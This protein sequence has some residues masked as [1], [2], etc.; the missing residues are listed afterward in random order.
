MS[1]SLDCD[2]AQYPY[3]PV[4]RCSGTTSTTTLSALWF[5]GELGDSCDDLCEFKGYAGCDEV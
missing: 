4:C 2:R 5:L 3:Q 1:G